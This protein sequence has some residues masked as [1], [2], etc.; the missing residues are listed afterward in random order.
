MRFEGEEVPERRYVRSCYLYHLAVGGAD[1]KINL[2][3]CAGTVEQL[4]VL[5]KKH[6]QYGLI[7]SGDP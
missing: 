1:K 6:H 4:L 7:L 5:E 2:F 3:D